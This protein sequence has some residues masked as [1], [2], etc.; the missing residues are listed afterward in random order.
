MRNA[1]SFALCLALPL[2]FLG[3]TKSQ[4]PMETSHG[5]EA[6]MSSPAPQAGTDTTTSG[7]LGFDLP[8]DWQK[9]PPSSSM[10]MAQ[11]SIPGDA[12]A[13]ELAVYH[14]G[15][16]QGGGVEANLDRWVNQVEL[17]PGTQPERQ[18]FEVGNL[19]VTWVA[20]EGTLKPS[21]TGMGPSA[22]KPDHALFGAVV[23]GPGGPWFFKATGPAATLKNQR[24][25][26]VGL[27]K[28]VRLG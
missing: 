11:A 22:P 1:F 18:S 26:F 24:D 20:V 13:G 15:P 27:L 17:A 7:T 8:Q 9:E 19:K 25:A 14:F 3:C 21:S 23:E 2:S 6:P 10:R 16:G 5:T 12:G 28:S 4:P